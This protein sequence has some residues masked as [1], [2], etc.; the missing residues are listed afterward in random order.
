V[1]RDLAE[2]ADFEPDARIGL[3]LDGHKRLPVLGIGDVFEKVD[4]R[5]DWTG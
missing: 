4:R 3:C 1:S 2:I 5:V